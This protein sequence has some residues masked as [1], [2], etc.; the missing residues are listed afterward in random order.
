MKS[1]CCDK[2]SK[3]GCRPHKVRS[4]H[5]ASK[6]YAAIPTGVKQVF[7]QHHKSFIRGDLIE[8]I[9]LF[10]SNPINIKVHENTE[11]NGV[12]HHHD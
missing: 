4:F 3:G 11:I 10:L 2:P 9:P 8:K 1:A 7:L 5:F 6:A 12:K